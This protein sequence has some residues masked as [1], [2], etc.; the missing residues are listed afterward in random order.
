ML[1]AGDQQVSRRGGE[2][3]V[4]AEEAAGARVGQVEVEPQPAI[5]LFGDRLIDGKLLRRAIGGEAKGR[6]QAGQSLGAR[7][8]AGGLGQDLLYALVL[9][10]RH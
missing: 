5:G 2:G 4:G 8:G 9:E 6:D 7:I 1:V 3:R 10:L